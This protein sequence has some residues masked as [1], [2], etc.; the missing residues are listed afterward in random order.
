M[1]I[2]QV[3]QCEP[4]AAEALTIADSA[5]AFTSG[6]IQVNGVPATKAVFV[7][8]TAQVRFTVDGSTV[9]TATGHLV[10]IGDVVTITGKHAVKNFSA[11]R[12]GAT[13][14]AAWVTY[15]R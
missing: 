3:P 14:G 6:T 7:L 10:E 1:P 11:I 8:E 5:I 15:Y 2:D 4:G 12:T 9:G 13:S